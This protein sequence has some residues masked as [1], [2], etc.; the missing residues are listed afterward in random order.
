M[1]A[2]CP[3]CDGV[4]NITSD[5]LKRCGYCGAEAE[6]FMFTPRR[7]KVIASEAVSQTGD[8][9]EA[10]CYLHERNKAKSSCA[11]CGSFICA[12]CVT[13]VEGAEYCPKCFEIAHAQGGFT[14]TKTK[15]TNHGTH[16]M[17]VSIL[18]W[19][20]GGG[21]FS[22]LV[23]LYGLFV[24]KKLREDKRGGKGQLIRWCIG[25]VL[26]FGGSAMWAVIF[27]T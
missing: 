22:P 2:I 26:S 11:R 19:L 4:L 13:P 24:L 27:L 17:M 20:I 23:F 25:M 16:V 21:L 6:Y 12:I 7:K 14:V 15:F 9:V 3:F 1:R 8:G 10:N 18:A 5:G